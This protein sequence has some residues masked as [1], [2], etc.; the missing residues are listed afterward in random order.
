MGADAFVPELD[1][2]L[3]RAAYP[4]DAL[5]KLWRYPASPSWFITARNEYAEKFKVA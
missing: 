1:K 3:F 2:A 4:G 5:E